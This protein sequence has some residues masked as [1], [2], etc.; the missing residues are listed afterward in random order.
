MEKSCGVR[1]Y[2]WYMAHTHTH[3]HIDPARDANRPR[4]SYYDTTS[5]LGKTYCVCAPYPR[6]PSAKL[7][8]VSRWIWSEM[9][10]PEAFTVAIW[11]CGTAN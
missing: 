8:A 10:T 6:M 9:C 11:Y 3:T 4:R 5:R 2:Y 7:Q 1:F